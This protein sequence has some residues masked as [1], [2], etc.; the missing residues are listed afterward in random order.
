MDWEVVI[1]QYLEQCK[2]NSLDSKTLKAYRID[3]K[4]FCEQVGTFSIKNEN[5]FL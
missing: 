1:S 3:L 5:P 2:Q 4:Q